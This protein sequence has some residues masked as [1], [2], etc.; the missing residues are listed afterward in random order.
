MGLPRGCIFLING[1]D[2]EGEMRLVVRYSADDGRGYEDKMNVCRVNHEVH[3]VIAI[4]SL[5]R[6]RAVN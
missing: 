5:S 1:V 4:D 6:I 3:S 2:Q